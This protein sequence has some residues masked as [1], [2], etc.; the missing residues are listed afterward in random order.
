MKRP[1]RDYDRITVRLELSKEECGVESKTREG[2]RGQ[3]VKHS[4]NHTE[5]FG[6]NP[7]SREE[8]LKQEKA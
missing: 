6:I 7:Q 8:S 5:E 3:V 2:D 1:I 4:V